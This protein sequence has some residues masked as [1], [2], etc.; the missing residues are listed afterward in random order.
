MS[1]EKTF[2]RAVRAAWD[3]I[4]AERRASRRLLSSADLTHSAARLRAA[5]DGLDALAA[6]A[7]QAEAAAPPP[8]ANEVAPKPKTK[9]KPKKAAAAKAAKKTKKK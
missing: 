4:R 3:E 1:T 7:K 2:E 5:A 6:Q 8:P 9:R